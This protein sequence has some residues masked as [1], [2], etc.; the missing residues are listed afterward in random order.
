M[1]ISPL[2]GTRSHHYWCVQTACA[3]NQRQLSH[4]ADFGLLEV[5]PDMIL[6]HENELFPPALS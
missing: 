5:F 3:G 2:N 6:T 4:R 1:L